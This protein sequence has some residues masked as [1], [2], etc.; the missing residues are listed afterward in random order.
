MKNYNEVAENVFNRRDEYNAL[1]IQQRKKVIKTGALT[2]CFCVLILLGVWTF[3]DRDTGIIPG[4][5][6]SET[7][8]T[9]TAPDETDIPDTIPDKAGTDIA[10]TEIASENISSV[11]IPAIELP[12]AG[13][14]VMMDMI[15]LVVYNGRIYTQAEFLPCDNSQKQ[16]YIGEYLGTASGTIDEWSEQS[17]YEKELASNI[18]GDV[19]SV[20]GYDKDF[21]ICIPE[22]YDDNERIAFFENLNGIELSTGKDLF[23]ERLKLKDNYSDVVYQLHNDW[24]YGIQEYRHFTDISDDDISDFIS[25]LYESPFMD[26]AGTLPDIYGQNLTQAHIYFK[27]NDGTTVGIRLFENGYVTYQYLHGL[28]FVKIDNDIY[29]RLFN[30]AIK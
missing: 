7:D 16:L 4:N 22:M 8:I 21:R 12:E 3:G 11:K 10:V 1:K 9:D 27:M 2:A 20:N 28:V 6:S 15:G 30:A 29:Q 18:K 25:S 19:Y 13:S 24:D 14:N 5:G 17:E 23:E 26:L